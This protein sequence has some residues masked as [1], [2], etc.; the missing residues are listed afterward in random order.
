MSFTLHQEQRHV[1]DKGK[2]ILK[3]F[4]IV[5]LACEVR[6]GKNFMSMTIAH[7]GG[8]RIYRKVLFATKKGAIPG[9]EKDFAD[10][11]FKFDKFKIINFEQLSK[12]SPLYDLI[13]VDEAHSIG[14]FAKKSVRA[15]ELKRI[16]S[17]G[18]D[19]ILMSG[20]PTPE[21]KS[22]IFHQFWISE[23]S[24][25]ASHYTNFHKWAKE[26]VFVKKRWVNGYEINDY[27]NAKGDKIDAVLRPYT[28]TLS[29]EQAGFQAFVD[30]EIM[31][32]DV[33]PKMY[34]L[35][36]VLKKDKIYKM[37]TRPDI[38]VADTPVRMQSLFHQI[39]SGTLKVE[40]N[41]MT[42]DE[43]KARFIKEQF[44]GKKIA[45]YY[46]FIQ[47]GELLKKYFPNWT[48]DQNEFNERNDL[49]FIRQMV[50]GREG[51]NLSTADWLV[52]YNIAFSATTYWQVRARMQT[53][54]RVAAAKLAWIFSRYGIEKSVYQVVAKKKDFTTS[55]FNDYLI[56]MYGK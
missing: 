53:K 15:T 36:K 17:N 21:S 41:Y 34:A 35:M 1:V 37:K 30:E 23:L 28:V 45:I 42:L 26:Y 13:I 38:I 6:T 48:D 51:I 24:P 8:R 49:V 25:F 11:E 40:D 2:A 55:Y 46:L 18:A 39:S 52:M 5:Y 43:S 29:Q 27:S 56:S 4:G 54:D 31:Y 19:V 20:T 47:E 33:D 7:E 10:T 12:E 50:A 22:Q 14:A 16:A 44:R 32:V 3:Q 9:V